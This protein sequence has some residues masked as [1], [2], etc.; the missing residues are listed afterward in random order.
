MAVAL[1]RRQVRMK[2]LQMRWQM[3]SSRDLLS[4][5]LG[6]VSDLR[7]ETPRHAHK[8]NRIRLS[9]PVIPIIFLRI[10][11]NTEVR[12]VCG[13]RICCG[14]LYAYSAYSAY[15]LTLQNNYP[16]YPSSVKLLKNFHCPSHFSLCFS[17]FDTGAFVVGLFSAN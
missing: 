10:T 3:Q 16:Y 4:L 15:E 2:A 5:H 12:I 14:V 7:G 13:D 11:D 9:K 17:F 1:R 6:I 8:D